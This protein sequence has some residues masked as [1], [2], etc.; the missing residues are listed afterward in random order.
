M[1]YNFEYIYPELLE[2]TC[3]ESR[4]DR[5]KTLD[6]GYSVYEN[7]YLLPNK[8]A[9]K[10]G[11][12]YGGVVSEEGKFIMS[13][14]WHEGKRCD[15]YDFD[16][17]NVEC[18]DETAI[19]IGFFNPCWGHAITDNLKKLW[20]LETK[21]CKDILAKGAKIV[22]VTIENKEMPGY[23]KR[24]FEL[25]GGEL[26]DFEHVKEIVRFKRIIVPDNSFIADNGERYYTDEYR[27]IIDKIKSNI[28]TKSL[29][30]EKIYFSRT[31]IKDNRDFGE[32]RIERVFAKK[33]YKVVYP[34][35]HTV[36]E[37]I[38]LL[39]NCSSFA[40]TEGSI[41]H[42][43]VFCSPNTDVVIVRKC[44][45]VNKYQ[46]AVNS[47]SGINATYID[48]HKSIKSPVSSPWVGPF[49]LYINSNMRKWM[50]ASLGFY[51]IYSLFDWVEYQMFDKPLI[52][53]I[54]RNLFKQG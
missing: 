25:A 21:A 8:E 36:D 11:M 27:H 48:A 39:A 35:K 13:S 14:A 47:V 51:S 54:K 19:Y 5:L 15:K 34:E 3:A 24:L 12:C 18:V 37:Q 4:V 32:K 22:Y 6:L 52:K 28:Q 53:K 26:C 23:V 7:A 50:R 33:G 46:M 49:Y 40:S 1:T 44:Y 30:F 43:V 41:S 29:H 31:H 38:E 20:F 42:N 2:L 10:D 17:E 16:A 45:D 9:W